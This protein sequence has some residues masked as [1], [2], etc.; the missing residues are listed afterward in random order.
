MKHFPRT[1]EH[2]LVYLRDLC[3]V[4]YSSGYI[5]T[6][7]YL[8]CRISNLRK[9]ETENKPSDISEICKVSVKIPPFLV[10]KPEI[11]FFQLEAQFKIGGII[12]E[13]TTFNY[14]IS[15]LVCRVLGS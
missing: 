4:L 14:L 9:M 10:E 13:D 7:V 5:L 2:G 8:L 11:R 3:S 12:Q 6:V 15:Q 1:E